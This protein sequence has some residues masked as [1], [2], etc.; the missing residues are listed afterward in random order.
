MV[1]DEFTG[2]RNVEKVVLY[3]TKTYALDMENDRI[4]GYAD[5]LA[6]MR[7]AVYKI[8]MTDRFLHII[9][10]TNYG[11]E[12]D[13]IMDGLYVYALVEQKI[14]EALMQDERITAVH[15]FNFTRN[16]NKLSVSFTVDTTEGSMTAQREV[17]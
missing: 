10:S 14:T 13:K 5:G 16:K 2:L 1:P 8:L 17:F 3:P 11:T 9:Y 7:Q 12:L 4:K 6:A 15:D